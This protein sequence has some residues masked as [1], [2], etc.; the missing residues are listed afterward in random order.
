MSSTQPIILYVTSNYAH[1]DAYELRSV[2]S[3]EG[4]EEP[5]PDVAAA[6]APSQPRSWSHSPQQQQ[7]Q[8]APSHGSPA[9]ADERPADSP[10]ALHAAA[11]DEEWQADCESSLKQQRAAKLRRLRKSPPSGAAAAGRCASGVAQQQPAAG[12]RSSLWRTASADAEAAAPAGVDGPS[13]S[14]HSV[15]CERDGRQ[16]A[17]SAEAAGS[18]DRQRG[19]GTA[20]GML[21]RPSAASAQ[22]ESVSVVS[23]HCT[24]TFMWS[25]AI[26][27]CA[28]RK[29]GPSLIGQKVEVY[30]PED[31]AWYTGDV[32]KYNDQEVL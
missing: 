17:A 11:S 21:L 26:V 20:A 5:E 2:P 9:E 27:D 15:P 8:Q 16:G 6:E 7:R 4:A 28:G 12:A 14:F 32:A 19:A 24:A 3:M 18:D 22:E 30:W 31:K 29:R 1:V 25:D 10:T 13:S 23:G